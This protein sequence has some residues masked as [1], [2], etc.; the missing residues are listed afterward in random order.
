MITLAFSACEFV[1]SDVHR[2][3]IGKVQI[4]VPEMHYPLYTSQTGAP[5][6]V[7]VLKT[8]EEYNCA[9]FRINYT[10][11]KGWSGT[12][13]IRLAGAA[14]SSMCLTAL[15]PA[16]AYIP[17][18]S[19][20]GRYRLLLMSGDSADTYD[21]LINPDYIKLRALTS[22]FTEPLDSVWWRYPHNTMSYNCGTLIADSGLCGDFLDTLNAHLSLTVIPK[23]SYGVW[24]YGTST[25]HWFDMHQVTLRYES[26]DD[27]VK[28]GQL[29]IK[30]SKAVLSKHTGD[31]MSLHNWRNVQYRSWMFEFE[32]KRQ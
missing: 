7:I 29:L 9:N 2:P 1:D 26:E 10:V 13:V 15:G 18:D 11:S 20:D 17:F 4:S 16:V 22:T 27:C 21:L 3:L 6:P 25:G 28:A 23:P 31:A 5:L 19:A 12:T 14:R 32:T 30:Y 8:S 24:P